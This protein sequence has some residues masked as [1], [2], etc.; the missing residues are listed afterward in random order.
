MHLPT[1]PVQE[2][3]DLAPGSAFEVTAQTESTLQ[4]RLSSVYGEV[5]ERVVQAVPPVLARATASPPDATTTE[6][7]LEYEVLGTAGLLHYALA[8]AGAGAAAAQGGKVNT[9]LPPRKEA[10]TPACAKPKNSM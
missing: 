7:L 10:S 2:I 9:E 6:I 3:H 8:E 4:R 5:Q 1:P